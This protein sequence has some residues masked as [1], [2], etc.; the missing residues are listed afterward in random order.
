MSKSEGM[1]RIALNKSLYRS[2]DEFVAT[3]SNQ[4]EQDI[5]FIGLWIEELNDG[6]WVVLRSDTSC[7]CGAKCKK[8]YKCLNVEGVLTEYWDF[9]NNA[10]E[11]PLKGKYRAVLLGQWDSSINSKAVLGKS[12]V[13]E[14]T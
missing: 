3:L 7:P 9:K 2:E 4:T 11:H 10:C 6:E 8:K 5:K 13:F 1:V 12:D 14:I